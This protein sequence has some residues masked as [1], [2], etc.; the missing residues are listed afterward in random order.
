MNKYIT[1]FKKVFTLYFKNGVR[2]KIH[3]QT[4]KSI[5]LTFKCDKKFFRSK[6]EFESSVIKGMK[7][8]NKSLKYEKNINMEL[9]RAYLRTEYIM[10]LYIYI[11]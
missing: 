4:D 8:L 9:D 1:L 3:H 10:D 7:S 2:A 5:V 6:S 11:K